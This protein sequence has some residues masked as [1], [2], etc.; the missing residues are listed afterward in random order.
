MAMA[1]KKTKPKK[2]VVKKAKAVKRAKPAKKKKKKKAPA[3]KKKAPAKKSSRKK[4][5]N[6]SVLNKR[7][8]KVFA[9]K[10]ERDRPERE[11]GG[12]AFV[13][14]DGASR[15][16][17]SGELARNFLQAAETGKE[18]LEELSDEVEDEEEGGPFVETSGSAQFAGG[19]DASNP[20][21][22]DVEAFPTPNRKR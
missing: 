17:F 10:L 4:G 6:E 1:K 12:K 19:T 11:D 21:D 2:K 3:S 14:E 5:V 8:G 20:K 9:R 18:T 7:R 22:A 16:Q 15:D 13:R